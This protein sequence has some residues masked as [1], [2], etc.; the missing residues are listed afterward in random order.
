MANGKLGEQGIKHRH[1]FVNAA[2]E[3]AD[4]PDSSAGNPR[5]T[6]LPGYGAMV[7]EWL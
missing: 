1:S 3:A 7:V 2:S 4:D 6:R 5:R